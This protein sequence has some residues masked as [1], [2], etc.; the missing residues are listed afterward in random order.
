[1]NAPANPDRPSD[2]KSPRPVSRRG[3]NSCDDEHNAGDLPDVASFFFAN[4][5]LA[6]FFFASFSWRVFL[7]RGGD[8]TMDI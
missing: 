4:F 7:R 6:G 8:S 2:S 3:L 1:V 5:F